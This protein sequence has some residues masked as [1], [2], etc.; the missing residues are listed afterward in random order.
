MG[1][2]KAGHFTTGEFARLCGVGKDTLFHYDEMG[3]FSPAVRGENGYR[4]YS[5][6]QLEV[7]YV[8]ATLKE[9]D[10]PL[11]EIRAYLDRRSPAEL[12]KLLD[13]EE[14][15][16]TE[17]L[18]R[19][20]RMRELIRRKA[21][22]TRE[23]METDRESIIL[24]EEGEALLVC[25][26]V[27]V[28]VTGRNAALS[29]AEHMRFCEE[30]E[31]ASPYAVGSMLGLE[32][33]RAGDF[34][35]GYSH[36]YTRVERVPRGVGVFVKPRGRYLSACHVGG[37]ETVGEV[38]RRLLDYAAAQALELRGPFFEDTLLDEL[39]V[40][41]YENYVLQASVLAP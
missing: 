26:P 38:Y 5:M 8:I 23:A 28:P 7:F 10:M 18:R 37:Y 3:V 16:L 6:N 22:L 33:A 31:I 20:K 2:Q 30:R 12:A 32:A 29:M 25:T 19:L 40:E 1:Q 21:A 35:R 39:S 13:R 9:L 14:R 17:K 27:R 15:L 34:E 11:A 41:G 36:F 24:R 4:Y